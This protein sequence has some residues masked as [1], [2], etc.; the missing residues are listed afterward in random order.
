MGLE[1]TFP[2]LHPP[3]NIP[4]DG[5]AINGDGVIDSFLCVC[6]FTLLLTTFKD[7]FPLELFV[8][9]ANCR[10]GCLVLTLL[11]KLMQTVSVNTEL[12]LALDEPVTSCSRMEDDEGTPVNM[13]ICSISLIEPTGLCTFM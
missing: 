7:T 6:L 8:L 13:L 11:L 10:L 5:A 4:L 12:D 1:F 9:F 3:D 2:Q